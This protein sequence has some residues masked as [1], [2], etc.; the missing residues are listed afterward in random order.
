V[1][2][3][4]TVILSGCGIKVNGGQMF[5]KLLQSDT[6]IK[7]LDLSFNTI[8]AAG[9]SA[10]AESLL[11]NTTLIS[12]NLRQNKIGM[13][14]GQAF[15]DVL[16]EN[17]TLEVLVVADNRVGPDIVCVIAGRLN[18]LLKDV[19]RSVCYREL[20]MPP[21]YAQGRFDGWKP[22]KVRHIQPG[23]I[24]DD[25][26]DEDKDYDTHTN[27]EIENDNQNT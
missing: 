11:V 25:I 3:V 7:E 8:E 1:K 26:D 17:Q 10:I 6:H 19:A 22:D 2:S 13:I 20:E 18:G 24:D 5:A 21:L 9:A 16:K 12:L 4:T 23:D 14:G 27:I 15:A